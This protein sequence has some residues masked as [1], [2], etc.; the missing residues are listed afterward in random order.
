MWL[1]ARDTNVE[2]EVTWRIYQQMIGAYRHPDRATGRTMLS[3]LIDALSSGVPTA[4]TELVTLGRTLKRR[5]VDVLAHFVP[6][7]ART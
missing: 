3:T 2:V 1:F 5:A 6:R 4:L 7:A